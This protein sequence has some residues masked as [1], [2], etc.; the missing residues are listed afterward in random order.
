VSP[1]SLYIVDGS[2]YIFRAYYA[3]RQLATAKGMPTNAVYGFTTMLLKLVREKKPDYL[4]VAFDLEKPTFREQ[5]YR[6]YKAHRPPAPD[7]LLPQFSLVREVVRAF[8]IPV[9]EIEGFEADD[10]IGTLTRIATARGIRV[11][12]VGSDKDLMQLVVGD[13]VHL[14]DT[15]KDKEYGPA[16]VREKFGVGPEQIVDLLGLTGD[17][18]DNIPGVPGIGDKTAAQLLQRYGSIENLLERGHEVPGKRGEVLRAHAEA[19]RISRQLAVIRTDVPLPCEL[20]DLRRQEP[21]ETALAELFHR[22]EFRTLMRELELEHGEAPP[23]TAIDRSR[24]RTVLTEADLEEVVAL[25]RSAGRFAI[26][27]ETTALD[28]MRAD[29][30]GVSLCW[31]PGEA[32]YIPLDHR[33]LGA[34]EQLGTV[35]AMAKLGPLLEDPAIAKVGQNAK[36]DTLVL[37]RVGAALSPIE[38]DTMVAA[39]LLD[40]G[41]PSYRLEELSREYLQHQMLTLADV[42]GRGK[43]QVAFD[44]LDVQT[45]TRHSAENAEVAYL[46]GEILGARI[47]EAG[48]ERLFR[49]VEL[50]LV[51]VLALMEIYGVKIDT[52]ILAELSRRFDEM[53]QRAEKRIF[54]LAGTRFNVNSPKQLQEVLFSQLGFKPARRTQTGFSTDVDVLEALARD[55]PL[56]REILEYRSIT[57]LKSTY[58]DALPVLMNPATGRI[59]TSYNQAVAATGR[60]SSS[61]PNLQNIPVRSD[62]GREIRR[63]FVAEDECVLLSA[64]Y[65]QIE[66]RLLAHLSGDATL[67]DAFQRGEDIHTRTAAEVLGVDRREVTP[68]MRNSAKAINF[69]IIYGMG[70]NRLARDLGIP[71]KQAQAYIDGYFD[72][73]SGVKRFI[74][75]TL[76]GA[77]RDGFVRT[78]LG[79]RRFLPDLGSRNPAVRSGAE[80]IAVNTP[81]QGSAADLIKV[82][83]VRIQ[84]ALE[85][86]HY[87]SRMILQ[88]HDELVFEVPEDEVEGLTELVRAEMEGVATLSVPLKVDLRTGGNWAEAH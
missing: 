21:D 80:R 61:D 58:V 39:Y 64:D 40:P 54:E 17:S 22:L 34:P 26:D 33:Y 48:L 8:N 27:T 16:Q 23:P 15:M 43:R 52:G 76:R 30:V 74:E 38:M 62:I 7:D 2:S 57:K 72:R 44:E 84:Q 77:R 69:G 63:A 32:C 81:I 5:L 49:E 53:A 31:K 86:E 88:V 19:A 65:S 67:Q 6:D 24:Y 78:L 79:R 51:R 60:L 42:A 46:L 87:V 68:E 35:R 4:A 59:H 9:L 10:V 36:Y 73:L 83:M 29:I 71:Q 20:E 56:P 12:I 37:R 55:H 41:K 75:A 50:P 11:T 45:A 3:I 47:Q 18:T 66:L 82:A 14:L 70:A 25:C 1:P 28:P 13:E 85:K